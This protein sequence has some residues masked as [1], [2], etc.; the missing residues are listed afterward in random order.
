MLSSINHP[1]LTILVCVIKAGTSASD[2]S[3]NYLVMTET[4]GSN[5]CRNLHVFARKV[6]PFLKE[7]NAEVASFLQK[8]IG[9]STGTRIV[10][11]I[12]FDCR[13]F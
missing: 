10:F 2:Q 1:L 11:L 3:Y 6:E 8:V 5:K 9:R 13:K 7:N 4:S 12:S